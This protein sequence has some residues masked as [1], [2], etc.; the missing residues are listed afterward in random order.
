MLCRSCCLYRSCGWLRT[1]SQIEKVLRCHHNCESF[2]GPNSLLEAV[3]KDTCFASLCKHHFFRMRIHARAQTH[4]TYTASLAIKR[5]NAHVLEHVCL[6]QPRRPS[7]HCNNG[8]LARE[9]VWVR[10]LAKRAEP[11]SDPE[12]DRH[13]IMSMMTTAMEMEMVIMIGIVDDCSD[14][15]GGG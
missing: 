4:I 2:Q 9:P 5:I 6:H 14:H 12:D 15:D 13:N 3:L 1:V 11:V 10:S 8:F 7:S